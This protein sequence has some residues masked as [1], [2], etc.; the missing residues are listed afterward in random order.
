[1]LLSS[2][3]IVPE[4]REGIIRRSR[5]RSFRNR[6]RSMSKSRTIEERTGNRRAK[7]RNINRCRSNR[8]RSRDMISRKRSRE[9]GAGTSLQESC[10][11]DPQE[12]QASQL[13]ENHCGGEQEAVAPAPGGQH[14]YHLC[15]EQ[16]CQWW[17]QPIEPI[18][19][20]YLNNLPLAFFG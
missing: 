2:W 8:N 6:S 3:V 20:L 1:M 4:L 16:L 5:N 15:Y 12:V 13:T 17:N 19:E 18:K 9:E 14:V 10:S 7:S 11:V